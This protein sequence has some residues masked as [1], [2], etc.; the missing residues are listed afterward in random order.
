M[1]T[2]NPKNK[3]I[4]VYVE[5]AFDNRVAHFYGQIHEDLFDRLLRRE[6]KE[7]VALETPYWYSE[8][9]SLLSSLDYQGA[10]VMYFDPGRLAFLARVEAT[11]RVMK[12]IEIALE[13]G[14]MGTQRT[15]NN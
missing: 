5:F 4:W 11:S 13:M 1:P 7:M 3:L 8:E 14:D 2:K 10:A 12:D 6:V 9:D 15:G